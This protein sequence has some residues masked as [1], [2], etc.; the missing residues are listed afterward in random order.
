MSTLL[1][2]AV[3]PRN[4]TKEQQI[5]AV[6]D[7]LRDL[8]MSPMDLVL[9]TVS[10]R[11]EYRT[12]RDGFYR[13]NGLEQ[14]LNVAEADKRGNKKLGEWMRYRSIRMVSDIIEGEMDALKTV[15]HMSVNDVTPAFLLDFNL[16]RDVTNA[17]CEKSPVLRQILLRAVC[18]SRA[19]HENEIKDA[20]AVCLI[21]FMFRI[22]LKSL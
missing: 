3:D 9:T 17:L 18:T 5:G 6:L 16:E 14:L 2:W 15:F 7:R 4:L 8:R 10:Q 13:S 1:I 12:S 22:H 11:P 19:D 20:A 21:T